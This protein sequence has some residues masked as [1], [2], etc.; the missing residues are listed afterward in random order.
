ME[1]QMAMN[2]LLHSQS[3]GYGGKQSNPLLGLAGQLIGGGKPH[4]PSHTSSAGPAGLVGALAG[5]L[6]G[7]GNKPNEGPQQSHSGQ[8]P[9]YGQHSGLAGKLGGFLGGQGGGH[10]CHKFV[11]PI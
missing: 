7:G 11:M 3:S 8:Q 9:Q 2:A 4:Q 10:V 5:S 6:L 1:Q